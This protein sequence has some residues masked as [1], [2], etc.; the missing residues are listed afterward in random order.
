MAAQTLSFH[1][2]MDAVQYMVGTWADQ[3]FP[4][5]TPETIHAHLRREV[6]ELAQA[7]AATE[8]NVVAV[9]EEIADCVLLLTHLAWQCGLNLRQLLIGKHNLNV[10][11][12]WGRPDAEG[13]VEH[14]R[15][16]AV[17]GEV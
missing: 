14:V 16:G 7:I 8:P 11:R 10:S 4:G 1:S 3:A 5:A 2:H 12:T 13:V 9:G 15:V 6:E 17:A